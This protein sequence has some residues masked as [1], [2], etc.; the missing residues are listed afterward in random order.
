MNSNFKK[1]T[2]FIL[3]FL[4]FFNISV[5]VYTETRAAE[6]NE[7]SNE[8]ELVEDEEVEDEEVNEA[9]KEK[10]E[11]SSSKDEVMDE[12]TVAEKQEDA[13]EKEVLV[14][15]DENSEKEEI[16]QEEYEFEKELEPNREVGGNDPKI[17]LPSSFYQASS[18][19]A[20]FE[21][22]DT[23]AVNKTAKRSPG[24]RTY[25]VT[26]DIT[27]EPQPAPVDVVLVIDRSGSMGFT[28]T[29]NPTRTRLYYAKQAAINF[30][31][32]LLGPNGIP[33]SRV[34]VVSFSGPTSTTGNGNQNQASL[35]LDLSTNLA[36]VTN[37]INGISALGGTNTEAGF[38]QGQ[39]VI[40]GTTSNQNPNSN[41]VVVMLTD[42]LPTASNGNKYEES[43]DIDH[44]HIQKAIA[45]G[46]NI[47]DNNIADVFTIGLT[48]GMN[49]IEKSLAN[50]ILTQAQNKGYY[51][52][53]SA[54]DLDAIFNAISQELGYAAT[55]AV[56]VDEVGDK[57]DLLESS[58]PA[59]VTYDSQ[60]RKITWKPGTIKNMAQLKY[61]VVAK[62]DFEGG[63]ADTNKFA[64]L[65]YKDIFGNP[66]TKNFPVPEVDVPTLIEI[67]LTDATIVSG[68]SISLGTGTDVDGENYMSPVTGG[69]NDGETFT[70]E[71]RKVGDSNVISTEKNPEVSPTEDTKYEVTVKDSNGCITKAT[72]WVR[73]TKTIDVIISK[74]V[75]GNMGN[76]EDEFNF[77]VKV[78]GEDKLRDFDLSH[79]DTKTLENIPINSVLTL[80]ETDPRGHTVTVKIGGEVIKPNEDGSYTIVLGD[81]DITVEVTNNKDVKIDT[82]ISFDNLPYIIMLAVSGLGVLAIVLRKRQY[83]I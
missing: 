83:K 49:D 55:N 13:V 78:D 38:K 14:E 41:K 65:T 29:T 75:T 35:D 32:R 18:K 45:A 56:V 74:K 16:V 36:T 34:S 53:P 37:I 82:G 4:I 47:Y 72:M 81:E 1:Y 58:L 6:E 46:K 54:T 39:A 48:T 76:M 59:G 24:C 80:T 17:T 11:G 10:G 33:G 40:Q 77:T 25:E 27:G 20:P 26:L 9:A 52:A 62:S 68:D 73:V 21:L 57:F 2:S 63:L 66:A 60:T 31:G 28:A 19:V 15:T 44:I 22:R 5:G 23:I 50:N 42:G 61:K 70:Y 67:S 79:G 12:G 3:A 71:W 7:V 51:P 30:A 64:K 69:D 8:E 43:T